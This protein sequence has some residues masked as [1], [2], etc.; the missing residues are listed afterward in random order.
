MAGVGPH[1]APTQPSEAEANAH[2]SLAKDL[3]NLLREYKV[4]FGTWAAIA[5]TG[6][7]SM[8]ELAELFES[9]PDAKARAK[10][11][12]GFEATAAG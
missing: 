4:H 12:L 8:A 3:Q 10:A 1:W 6:F 2:A 11:V 7:T 5:R 9:K